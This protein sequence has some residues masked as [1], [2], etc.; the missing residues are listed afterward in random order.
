MSLKPED[1]NKL[2]SS[3]ASKEAQ[4]I[5]LKALAVLGGKG[6]GASIAF[7]SIFSIMRQIRSDSFIYKE[8]EKILG[9]MSDFLKTLESPVIA[10]SL[11][12]DLASASADAVAEVASDSIEVLADKFQEAQEGYQKAFEEALAHDSTK[13]FDAR[14]QEIDKDKLRSGELKVEGDMIVQGSDK[15][16]RSLADSNRAMLE[17]MAKAGIPVFSATDLL[18]DSREFEEEVGKGADSREFAASEEHVSPRSSKE[19][20]MVSA[21]KDNPVQAFAFYVHPEYKGTRDPMQMNRDDFLELSNLSLK[22]PITTGFD[23]NDIVTRVFGN[24]PKEYLLEASHSAKQSLLGRLSEAA[25]FSP[26]TICRPVSAG[27]P[28]VLLNDN[29]ISA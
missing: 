20:L 27:K 3:E 25:V 16:V 2:D 10:P 6:E 11:P 14:G 24:A 28:F 18:K 26:P 15:D 29:Q 13:V 21:A 5:R 23:I 8:L 4:G 17:V 19:D 7:E 1:L 12:E 9:E 22:K